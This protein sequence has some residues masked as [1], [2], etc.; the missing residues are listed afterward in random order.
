MAMLMSMA[1]ACFYILDTT[2]GLRPTGD[3]FER[4]GTTE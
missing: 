2:P 4:G 1:I 3:L